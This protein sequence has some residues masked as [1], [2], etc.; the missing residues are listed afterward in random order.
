[1][2]EE[3]GAG[4][5]AGRLE[6]VGSFSAMVSHRVSPTSLDEVDGAVEAWLRAAYERAGK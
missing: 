5:D 2:A 6:A 4:V 1:M 3:K